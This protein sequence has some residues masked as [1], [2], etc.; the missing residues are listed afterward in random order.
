MALSAGP[1][2]IG[3][4][5]FTIPSGSLIEVN[6][7]REVADAIKRTGE[8]ERSKQ[9]K[10]ANREISELVVREARAGASTRLQW[11]AART[12]LDPV[13]TPMGAAVKLS[14]SDFPG[15]LGAEF[16]A[17]RNQRRYIRG[18]Q[19]QRKGWNQFKPWR[20]SEAGSGYFLWPAI[21]SNTEEIR[22]KYLDMLE[23]I[24]NEKG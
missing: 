9:W 19:G 24:F 16:G 1:R 17:D 13:T 22:S 18:K 7:L 12:A 4:I 14:A 23:R 3:G 15:A 8:P 11:R 6:G 10:V 2:N 20:G 5:N 21:R